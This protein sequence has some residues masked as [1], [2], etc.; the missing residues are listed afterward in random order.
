MSWLGRV[1]GREPSTPPA[2]KRDVV[3]EQLMGRLNFG[4]LQGSGILVTPES[5]MRFMAVFACVRVISEDIASLPLR[6]YRELKPRGRKP[7]PDHPLY[8]VLNSQP[9][10]EQTSMEWREMLQAH[11]LLWGNA[12][13]EIVRKDGWPSQLWPITPQRV[14]IRRS[15]ATG[16]LEYL[17]TPPGGNERPFTDRQIFHIK[18]LSLDGVTGVSPIAYGRDA[19][20]A[21]LGG[22]EFANAFFRQGGRP[23]GVIKYP[24]Q[25]SAEAHERL[26]GSFE[27]AAT[28]LTSAQRWILLE[29]GGDATAMLGMPL[30]DAQFIEQRRF[31]VEEIARLYRVTPHMI[32]DLERATFNNIEELTRAHATFTLKPWVE[33]WQQAINTRLIPEEERRTFYADIAMQA[34]LE[35]DPE[36]RSKFYKALWEMGVLSPND[37]REKENLNPVPDGDTYYVPMN[38]GPVGADLPQL[39]PPQASPNGKEPIGA[40]A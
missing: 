37:I 23:G 12:Y 3:L 20:G 4:Q 6:I 16:R 29:E 28:G 2:E 7:A 5:S 36:A 15:K 33:R 32:S 35:G 31:S 27:E 34:L 26:K 10:P 9:N 25:L 22:Q 24:G 18:G 11:L 14:S 38:F 40:A 8:E 17:I 19:I 1:L 13:C 21:G 39:G 30:E